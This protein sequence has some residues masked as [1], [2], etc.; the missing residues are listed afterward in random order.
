MQAVIR[1]YN[2][3]PVGVSAIAATLNESVTP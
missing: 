2:G 1:Q 3:G